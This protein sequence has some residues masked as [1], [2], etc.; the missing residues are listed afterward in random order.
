MA[1]TEFANKEGKQIKAIK[2]MIEELKKQ[3]K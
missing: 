2:A 3:V 1:G